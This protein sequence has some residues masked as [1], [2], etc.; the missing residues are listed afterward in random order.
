MPQPDAPYRRVPTNAPSPHRFASSPCPRLTASP[1]L[2]RLC[3]RARSLLT[4]SK[5]NP[6]AIADLYASQ[7]DRAGRSHPVLVP[8]SPLAAPDPDD[9]IFVDL[10]PL[11]STI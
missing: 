8:S 9:E 5:G 10:P 2:T 3:A 4:A 1:L 7:R 6:L 11:N